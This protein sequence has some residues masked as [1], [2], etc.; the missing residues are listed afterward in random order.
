MLPGRLPLFK[1]QPLRSASQQRSAPDL[2][3]TRSSRHLPEL[4]SDGDLSAR[5][6]SYGLAYRMQT[7]TPELVDLSRETDE[8]RRLYGFGEKEPDE[9]GTRCLLARRLA[10]AGVRFVQ[11]YSGDTNG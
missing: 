3:S 2:I 4:A 7:S 9:F 6:A 5:L 8:T 11:L 1:L 10:E